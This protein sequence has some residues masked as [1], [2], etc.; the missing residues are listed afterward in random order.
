MKEVRNQHI[1]NSSII[2]ISKLMQR[3]TLLK[4]QISAHC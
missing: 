4:Q 2:E 3:I 1:T